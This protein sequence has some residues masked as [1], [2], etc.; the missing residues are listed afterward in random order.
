MT[1][2][3]RITAVCLLALATPL[4][5][6]AQSVSD[7]KFA[8]GNFGT[9][10][11]GKVTGHDYADFRLGAQKGQKMFAELDVTQ[12]DGNG[13][14]YFNIMPPDDGMAIY[15]G[16]MDG[17]SALVTLPMDGTYTI[18]V[19]QMGNDEDSGKTSHFNLDLSIQ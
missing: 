11:E 6:S 4:S 5:L 16:S 2:F 7:V 9:M 13:T 14:V 18:R 8:K 3:I 17:N 12:T 19:Y 10:V 15:N 1:S